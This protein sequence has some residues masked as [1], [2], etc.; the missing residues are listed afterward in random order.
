MLNPFTMTFSISAIS[1]S[2]IVLSGVMEGSST[3]NIA[4]NPVMDGAAVGR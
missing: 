3:E 2:V 4:T 1:A